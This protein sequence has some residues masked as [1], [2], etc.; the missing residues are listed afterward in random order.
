MLDPSFFAR[1][2]LEVAQAMIGVELFVDDVGGMIVET[3]AY[4]PDDPASHSF[5]GPRNRNLH[6][7]SKPGTAYVYRIYGIH[8]CL[9]AVC[10]PGS[11]VLIRALEPMH[12]LARMRERRRLDDPRLLCSGPGRLAQALG[13]DGGYNGSDMLSAPFRLV[14]PSQAAEIAIG[15]RIGI[16]KAAR[17]PWRFGFKKSPYLSRKI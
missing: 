10:L 4:L 5:G 3:E 16:T 13:I 8:F 12:G 2:A 17:Q 6:M 9:N 7:W 15:T 14:P 1:D 11:V